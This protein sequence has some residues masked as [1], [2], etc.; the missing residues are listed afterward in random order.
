MN[1]NAAQRMNGGHVSV[2]SIMRRNSEES[3]NPLS[4]PNHTDAQTAPTEPTPAAD[5]I[6]P[7]PTETAKQE[8]E[9][10][11]T[12]TDVP[13]AKSEPVKPIHYYIPPSEEPENENRFT[14]PSVRSF[15][16]CN[17]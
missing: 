6:P 8:Q 15:T 11:P 9:Q 16:D 13:T 10:V 5:S 3:N 12:P 17:V 4:C 7:V 2:L 14:D 1:I